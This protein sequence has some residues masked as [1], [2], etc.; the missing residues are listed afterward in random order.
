[1]YT[2]PMKTDLT[3]MKT[4]LTT[5][6]TD[7]MA[8][9]DQNECFY[10]VDQTDNYGVEYRVFTYRLASFTDFQ[11]RNATECRGH[12]FRKDGDSWVLAS[13][14]MQ[15][16]WNLG[17]HVGWGTEMDFN[18]MALIADKLDGSLISTVQGQH[19]SHMF[20]KSKTSFT[21]SQA[22]AATNLLNTE[23]YRDFTNALRVYL[24]MGYTV[25]M[26][27]IAPENQIVIGYA[28]PALKVL[29]A[30]RFK[31][32]YIGDYVPYA[33]LVEFFGED[34]VVKS[35]P[36]PEDGAAFLKAVEG[37]T[38]IEGFV[39]T[40][41]NGLMFKVKT[42]AYV[43]AHGLVSNLNSPRRLY[44]IILMEAIDD[45]IHIIKAN[46][47]LMNMVESE[48]KRIRHLYTEIQSTVE[49]FYEKNKALSRKDY[50][51][52]A[53]SELPKHLMSLAMNLWLNKENNYKEWMLK[54]YDI[55][56]L[57]DAESLVPVE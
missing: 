15:K 44:E 25:N 8:L 2:V 46:E 4:D 45:I 10:F 54:K 29:N 9:C 3:P 7:L 21:S 49:D 40:L 27:Y 33:E 31:E 34:F 23:K 12:T 22:T 55:F 57:S 26:E 41:E 13:L 20:L 36:I 51:I 39:I 42:D 30:R 50:A 43:A 14:P 6:F 16:F 52:L 48:T 38:G 17:E 19:G 56:K 32:P 47:Y 1:M 37:M 5:L 11:N 35:Y 28:E 24:G 18:A 53:Q